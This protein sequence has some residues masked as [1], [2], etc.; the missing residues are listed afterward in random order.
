MKRFPIH[1]FGNDRRYRPE[2]DLRQP[3]VQHLTYFGIV[4]V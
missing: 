3:S 2:P 1:P 4:A